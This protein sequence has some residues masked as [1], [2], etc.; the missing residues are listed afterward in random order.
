MLITPY[1]HISM[2]HVKAPDFA[3]AASIDPL[4]IPG[5]IHG[6]LASIAVQRGDPAY[7]GTTD[8]AAL[9]HG[10]DFREEG[11][12]GYNVGNAV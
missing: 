8:D 4:T 12:T 5:T 2:P 3:A 11:G 7:Y 1:L 10:H 9:G 6:G